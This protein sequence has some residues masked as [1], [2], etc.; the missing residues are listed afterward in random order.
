MNYI[1]SSRMYLP[2]RKGQAV[3]LVRRNGTIM[4]WKFADGFVA[5]APLSCAKLPLL[6]RLLKL[7]APK[8]TQEQMER[9][10]AQPP[11]RKPRRTQEGKKRVP[12]RTGIERMLQEEV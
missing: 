3:E 2:H 12:L 10:L 9:V 1:W 6:Y 7:P 4:R 5:Q 8:S 11:V